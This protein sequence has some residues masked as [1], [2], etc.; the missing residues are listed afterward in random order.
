MTTT[1]NIIAILL[2]PP[3]IFDFQLKKIHL[4]NTPVNEIQFKSIKGNKSNISFLKLVISFYPENFTQ[5]E[6]C[7]RLFSIR[8]YS[9]HLAQ[10]FNVIIPGTFM[11][12]AMQILRI[13]FILDCVVKP[14]AVHGA[15][16][17]RKFGHF[18]F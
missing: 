6:K 10:F 13:L 7:L 12:L 5:N 15:F 16:Q 8:K 1:N 18:S 4:S 9:G 17:K 2:L 14:L 3:S 11:R